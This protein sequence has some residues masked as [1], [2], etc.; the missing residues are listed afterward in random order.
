MFTSL[1]IAP[2]TLKNVMTTVVNGYKRQALEGLMLLNFFVLFLQTQSFAANVQVTEKELL[3]V[4]GIEKSFLLK[5]NED[6]L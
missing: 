1:K 4:T 5:T 2:W 3:E 6:A